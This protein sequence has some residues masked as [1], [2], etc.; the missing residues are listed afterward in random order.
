ME[1]TLPILVEYYAATW[2]IKGCSSKTLIGMRSNL[3]KFI[4]FLQGRGHSLKLAE[5]SIQDARAYVAH[6]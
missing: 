2:Q 5:V 4:H 1:I 3:A 6:L